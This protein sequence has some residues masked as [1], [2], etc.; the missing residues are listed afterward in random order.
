MITTKAATLVAEN[1][2]FDII[3]GMKILNPHRAMIVTTAV[4]A[5]LTTF[6]ARAGD[7]FVIQVVD[8]QTGRGVPLVELRTI[9]Q[10]SWWTDSQGVVVFDEPGLM[11]QEVYF[12]VQSHGY[13]YPKDGFGNRGVKLKTVRGGKATV[14]IERLN[15]AE[16]LYRVTGQGIYRDTVLA[17]RSAP[18]KQP[19]LNGQVLGQDTV[20]ATPYRGKIFWFWGD[21]ERVSYPLGNFAVSGATSAWPGRGGLDPSVGVDLTYFVDAS[22]FSKQM[23]QN[24]GPG[25]H[26]IEG[27]MTVPDETGRERLVARVSSQKGLAP[28]YAWHL[29]IFNDEKEI[30]ESK[31]KWELTEGHDSSHPFRAR[32]NGV[33]YLYLYPNYRVKAELKS[34]SDLKNYEAFTCV[35]GDGKVRGD[36]TAIERDVTGQAQYSWKA[37]ADRLHSG[38][39]RDMT[40]RGKLKPEERWIQLRDIETGAPLEAGRGSVFWNE[41]RR[42]WVML[43]SSKPGEIWFAEG[44]TPTGPWVYARRVVLHHNYNFYN[45]T[46]HPFFDQ[47]GGRLIYFEGTY[48]ASFSA[49]QEK[50]PRYDY[51]QI[52]YRLDL[53][54]P[55]LNLPVPVYRQATADGTTRYLTRDDVAKEDAWDQIHELVFFAFPPDRGRGGVVPIFRHVENG[56]TVLRDAPPSDGNRP[57]FFALPLK[58]GDASDEK[59]L[60]SLAPLFEYRNAGGTRLYSVEAELADSTWQRSIEPICRVWKNPGKVLTLDH[61]AKPALPGT[62]SS[63][64]TER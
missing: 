59:E 42:R 24:F 34:L 23:C 31:V 56:Q 49:A 11:D 41:F 17:G 63:S 26:W 62:R 38:R 14:K 18:L 28:A 1:R 51:N 30:F 53:A 16:R 22:G 15:I 50:T 47:A 32:V 10:A 57:A 46:Q 21:T 4:L 2:A 37:G 48:T 40:A 5:V 58:L 36:A 61:S 60:P 25:L 9:N 27:V 55:R 33:E 13:E 39:L 35:A 3:A 64:R 6:R 12:H 44:D 52:M 20:I 29:A 19:L 54:D 45:P 43:V 7:F 8:D